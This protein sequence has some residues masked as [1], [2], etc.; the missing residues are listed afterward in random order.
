MAALVVG[1]VTAALVLRRARPVAALVVV[2]AACALGAGPLPAGA[3]AVLGTAGVALAL[4]TVASERDAFTAVLSV[5][6]LAVWQLLQGVTLHGLRERDG[7]DLA[8]TAVLYAAACGAG[9]LRRRTGRARAAAELLLKRAESE[10]HRLPAAERRRMERE[11][12]DVSAHHLTTVVVTAGAA[13]GLRE[14]RPELAREALDFAVETGREVTRALGAVRAPAPFRED[15]PS[16]RERLLELVAGFRQLDQPVLPDGA[17]MLVAVVF[18][19][20]VN[21]AINGWCS[22]ALSRGDRPG[23]AP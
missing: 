14:R 7:L 10:R 13:L 21:A 4:F 9:V 23:S 18:G 3:T 2:V 5:V 11:L 15:V 8:L 6:A 1:V 16:P 22:R 12:H 19:A 17:A 20:L